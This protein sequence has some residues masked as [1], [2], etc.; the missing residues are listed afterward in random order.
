MHF[1]NYIAIITVFL[2]ELLHR[3]IL[4]Y[5]ITVSPYLFL[6]LHIICIISGIIELLKVIKINSKIEWYI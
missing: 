5:V 3:P 1:G 4:S 6:P 2:S